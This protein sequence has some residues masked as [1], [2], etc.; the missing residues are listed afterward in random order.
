VIDSTWTLDELHSA[1]DRLASGAQF[2]KIAV[3][4]D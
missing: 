2:G 3:R 4:V 1:L